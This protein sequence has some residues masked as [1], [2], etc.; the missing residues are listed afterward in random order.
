MQG[1]I[2]G[3]G[4]ELMLYGMAT[5]VL[6][7]ALLVVATTAMSGVVTRYF[8]EPESS[9]SQALQRLRAGKKPAARS[10]TDSAVHPDRVAAITAAIHQYRADR[11]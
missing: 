4:L 9:A 2:V 3:Q 8:P 7:L 6:F 1:D 11:R 5:V 10:A